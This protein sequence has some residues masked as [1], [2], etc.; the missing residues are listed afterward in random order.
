MKE[1]NGLEIFEIRELIRSIGE[2]DFRGN[3]LFSFFH[4]NK[5]VDLTKATNLSKDFI[6]KILSVSFIN[7][8]EIFKIYKSKSDNTEKYLILLSR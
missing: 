2:K 7:K 5:R 6:N 8:P 4:K 1:L 3:Q